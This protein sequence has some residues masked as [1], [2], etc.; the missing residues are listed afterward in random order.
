MSRHEYMIKHV[1]INR[2]VLDYNFKALVEGFN[3]VLP[4]FSFK[5][6]H[7]FLAQPDFSFFNNDFKSICYFVLAVCV[8]YLFS[9][10]TGF[11]DFW[12]NVFFPHAYEQLT[13]NV[14]EAPGPLNDSILIDKMSTVFLFC[15]FL[16][17]GFYA[18]Y[19]FSFF[20]DNLSRAEFL[21]QIV[22]MF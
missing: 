1:F 4:W 6:K 21:C 18:V 8:V 7:G 5:L 14:S 16:V 3:F 2:D 9:L 10:W 20:F 13:G 19:S 15:F 12:F 17:F 22:C 11:F